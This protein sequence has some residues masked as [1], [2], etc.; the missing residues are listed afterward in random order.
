MH[1]EPAE[2]WHTFSAT[3]FHPLSEAPEE[4]LQLAPPSGAAPQSMTTAAGVLVSKD[5]GATWKALGD[6]EVGGWPAAIWGGA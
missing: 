4:Q 1:R 6:I 2:S 5:Q 3:T